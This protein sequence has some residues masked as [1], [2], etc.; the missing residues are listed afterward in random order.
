MSRLAL[1]KDLLVLALIG[2]AVWFGYRH[3]EHPILEWLGLETPK[4][5]R[6]LPGQYACE[7]GKFCSQLKSCDE[8]RYYARYCG[9]LRMEGE[10]D[11]RS[12]EQRWCGGG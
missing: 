7:P 11:G 12:C 1:L 6:V 2:A 5:V 3:F 10:L 4:V 9:P 8:A